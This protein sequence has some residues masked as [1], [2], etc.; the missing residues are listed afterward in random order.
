MYDH[1]NKLQ[2]IWKSWNSFFYVRCTEIIPCP[3]CGSDLKTIGSRK[4]N[5]KVTGEKTRVLIIRRLRCK[6][7]GRI[8]HELPD[9]LVPYKRYAALSI[10]QVLN[11]AQSLPCLAADDVTLYR[12]RRWFHG[13]LPYLTRCLRSIAIRLN[14]DPVKEPSVLSQS[15]HQ[16][17][18]HYVG[19]SP[20]WLARIV[21]PIVNTNLWVHTRFA[22]LSANTC[23]RLW[24]KVRREEVF[25]DERSKEGGRNRRKTGPAHPALTAAGLG[26]CLRAG[27]KK[28]Y[29]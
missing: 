10:E 29:L 15:V 4:R 26:L 2:V 16:K 13:I 9:C 6:N 21:R 23:A 11:E 12:L 7:C 8:H 17:I 20:G 5:S 25:C 27:K 24:R 14:Q 19:N 22:F 3:C 18:G 1:C 28:M